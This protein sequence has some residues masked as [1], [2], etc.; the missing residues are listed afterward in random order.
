MQGIDD[1]HM[2]GGGIGVGRGVVDPLGGAINR[3]QG[4]GQ[5]ER[6][7]GQLRAG[8]VGLKFPRPADRRLHQHGGE[9]RQQRHQ[10]HTHQAQRIAP[11]AHEE[12]EIGQ[13]AD[14]AGDHRG[15]GHGQGIAIAHMAQF[16][17]DHARQLFIA[18][19][20]QQPA[21]D[22]DCGMFGI[23]PGG[24]GIGLGIFGNEHLGHRQ[25][26]AG[27]QPLDDMIKVGRTGRIH[28]A[29]AIHPQQHLVGIPIGEQVQPGRDHKRDHHAAFA[30]DHGAHHQE[31]AHH[32]AHQQ[33][34]LEGVHGGLL[35]KGRIDVS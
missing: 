30:A 11:P 31:Q 3:R 7:P 18:H 15:D 6:P 28:L 13:H 34:G 22:T 4:I 23:A 20:R 12:S 24:E 17:R 29:R 8:L 19:P 5:P 32:Q 26:R 9:W 35:A 14:G 10:Q 2:G 27:R 1:E 25:F 21:G 33:A 16:V